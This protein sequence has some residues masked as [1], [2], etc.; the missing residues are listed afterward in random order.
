MAAPAS[1]K[2]P[3]APLLKA[4]LKTARARSL[5]IAMT[6]SVRVA[7]QTVTFSASGAERP[8]AHQMSLVVDMSKLN[9]TV[10]TMR[11]VAIG[12]RYYLHYGVLDALHR[13]QPQIKPWLVT[14]TA[15]AVGFDPW[16]L[17]NVHRSLKAAS[18][19]RLL[20][21]GGGVRRYAARIDLRAAIAA[22]PQLKHLLARAGG[23]SS[24]LLA[25]PVPIVLDVGSDGYLHRVRER[26][27]MPVAGQS[28]A[29]TM[30][31]RLSRFDLDPGP[32]AA[33]P[34]DEVMTLAQFQKL[35]AASKTPSA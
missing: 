6:T 26:L 3:P 12:S 9:P 10:G 33:P 32:I 7:G 20:R 5:R 16:S 24:A 23:G 14:D 28:L 35:V 1:G 21:T 27:T 34:A 18:G 31:F 15:S 2:Q 4:E 13:K 8:K 17:G 19:Y 29:M 22:N 30:D 25:R 11:V